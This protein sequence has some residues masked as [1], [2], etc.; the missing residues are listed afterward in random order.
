MGISVHD[1]R[2]KRLYVIYLVER[3][4]PLGEQI[5]AIPLNSNLKELLH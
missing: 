4:Y 3:R 2:L 1:L 5:E